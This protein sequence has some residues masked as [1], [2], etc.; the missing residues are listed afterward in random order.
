MTRSTGIG[1]VLATSAV[2]R[3]MALA[4]PI[5]TG[6]IVDQ[7]VPAGDDRIAPPLRQLGAVL[8]AR[9]RAAEAEPLLREA[10]SVQLAKP[11]PDETSVTITERM[12]GVC[13]AD[14]LNGGLR[15]CGCIR[16]LDLR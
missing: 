13:L 5:L 9:G 8:T 14:G 12:L 6:V 16:P 1:K 10:L 3:L 11:G 4:V 15:I 7:I 2:V